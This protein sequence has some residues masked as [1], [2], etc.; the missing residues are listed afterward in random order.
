MTSSL[1]RRANYRKAATGTSYSKSFG[2]VS[3][4]PVPGRPAICPATRDQALLERDFFACFAQASAADGSLTGIGTIDSHPAHAAIELRAGIDL[5]EAFARLLPHLEDGEVLGCP[6]VRLGLGNER[7][8]LTNATGTATI[9]LSGIA[10]ADWYQALA[11]WGEDADLSPGRALWQRPPGPATAAEAREAATRE[12]PYSQRQAEVASALLRR[13]GLFWTAISPYDTRA[14]SGLAREAGRSWIVEM[15]FAPGV[16][17]GHHRLVDALIHP[18]DG[19]RGLIPGRCDGAHQPP[20]EAS[21]RIDLVDK[22]A[23]G[24]GVQLRFFREH[25]VDLAWRY[26]QQAAA[27]GVP[28]QRLGA[29][30]PREFTGPDQYP[31]LISQVARSNRA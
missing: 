20:F 14:W 27:D 28:E 16:D 22:T 24:C 18:S 7:A 15:W 29:M 31:H 2:H 11:Q 12:R 25:A 9:E 4:S 10:I 5:D 23:S 30:Y 17:A 13:A 1:K 19:I 26:R 21:C 6:G 3:A 8:V